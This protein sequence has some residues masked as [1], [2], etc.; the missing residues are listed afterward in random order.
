MSPVR[1]NWLHTY[2][3]SRERIGESKGSLKNRVEG[4]LTG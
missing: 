2:D 3:L 1:A 4:G